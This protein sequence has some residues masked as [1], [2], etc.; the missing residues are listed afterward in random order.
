MVLSCI[1]TLFIL[2]QVVLL[3]ILLQDQWKKAKE[4][5]QCQEGQCTYTENTFNWYIIIHNFGIHSTDT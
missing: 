4:A 3:I 5:M 1:C 2:V